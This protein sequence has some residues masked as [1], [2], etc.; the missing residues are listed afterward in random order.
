MCGPEILVD[1]TPNY[2][3]KMKNKQLGELD[4]T[5]ELKELKNASNNEWEVKLTYDVKDVKQILKANR[6]FVYINVP[7]IKRA[8]IRQ[9]E[10]RK[11]NEPD[12]RY[13]LGCKLGALYTGL[14][15]RG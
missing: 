12:W 11:S 13:C 6:D 8:F 9:Q 15:G 7:K 3:E 10:F 2:M 14:T 1:L 5:A 4:G